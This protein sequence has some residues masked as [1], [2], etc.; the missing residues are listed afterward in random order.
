MLHQLTAST[1]IHTQMQVSGAYRPLSPSVEAEL[2]SVAQ[3]AVVNAVRHAAASEIQLRLRFEEK[4]VEMQ[5]SDNGRG[6]SGTPAGAASGHFG[7]TGM[8]ERAEKIGGELAIHS[9]PGEGTQLSL[10]VPIGNAR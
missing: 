8:R 6:F 1:S 3:E 2:L 5:I 4:S 9:K 7:L 10:E